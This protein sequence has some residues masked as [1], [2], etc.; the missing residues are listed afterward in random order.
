MDADGNGGVMLSKE[1]LAY[2]RAY[3]PP[4]IVAAE[5]DFDTDARLW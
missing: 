2:L 1:S 3:N 5:Y 4:Q